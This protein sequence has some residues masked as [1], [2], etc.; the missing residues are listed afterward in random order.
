[1]INKPFLKQL[2]RISKE[3]NSFL[4]K[5]L[6]ILKPKDFRKTEEE[7]DNEVGDHWLQHWVDECI[8][9]T[10]SSHDVTDAEELV[11]VDSLDELSLHWW[12][13]VTTVEGWWEWYSCILVPVK[14]SVIY[15]IVK[16]IILKCDGDS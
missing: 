10:N 16:F 7:V 9:T 5:C 13:D 14:N 8:E 11:L 2:L 6:F 12:I 3:V 15:Q 1:M 4:M